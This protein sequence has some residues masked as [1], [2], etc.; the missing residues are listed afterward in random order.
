MR[1]RFMIIQAILIVSAILGA[2]G[3][4]DRTKREA[5]KAKRDR[6]EAER[7]ARYKAEREAES[8]LFS[9]PVV[10]AETLDRRI[11]NWITSRDGLILVRGEWSNSR[12][13]ARGGL[14]WNSMPSTTPWFVQC[15]RGGL[16][17]NLGSWRDTG[18]LPDEGIGTDNVFGLNVTRVPLSDDQC[19]ELVV[20]AGQKMLSITTAP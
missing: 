3:E 16:S 5:E 10:A 9:D 18:G 20:R 4:G 12:R 6:E 13:P 8:K 14:T 2:C 15:G 19:K 7:S 17:I 1:S 11:N